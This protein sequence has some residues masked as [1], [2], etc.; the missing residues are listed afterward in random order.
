MPV[1]AGDAYR[2]N[3]FYKKYERSGWEFSHV[4]LVH[5]NTSNKQLY[6][7]M[8][9]TQLSSAHSKLQNIEY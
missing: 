1:R 8:R 9:I 3:R 7:N 5:A 2:F 4:R 6:D